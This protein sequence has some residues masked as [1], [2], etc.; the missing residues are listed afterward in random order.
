MT[1]LADKWNEKAR[2][3]RVMAKTLQQAR[4]EKIW[5]PHGSRFVPPLDNPDDF[6]LVGILRP[7][8]VSASLDVAALMVSKSNTV[9]FTRE[10]CFS[11]K[12]GLMVPRLYPSLRVKDVKQ[13][14]LFA[15]IGFPSSTLSPEEK[16]QGIGKSEHEL[17]SV[18]RCCFNSVDEIAFLGQ[19]Q[20]TRC[21]RRTSSFLLSGTIIRRK[22]H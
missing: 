7:D 17:I 2:M 14:E 1:A 20:S 18:D 19:G 12:S 4:H 5:E 10:V 8:P 21:L 6:A 16:D 15:T 11:F 3:R 9:P 22:A 13:N